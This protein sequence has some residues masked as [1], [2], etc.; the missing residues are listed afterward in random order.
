MR[1]IETCINRFMGPTFMFQE[2]VYDGSD[3]FREK[4]GEMLLLFAF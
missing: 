3:L 4:I 2:V 1:A